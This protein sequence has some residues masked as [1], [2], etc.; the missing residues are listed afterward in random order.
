M[1]RLAFNENRANECQSILVCIDYSILVSNEWTKWTLEWIKF[2]LK[3]AKQELNEPNEKF[4]E[5]SDDSNE[6]NERNESSN[7][8]NESS[9]GHNEESNERDV[10]NKQHESSLTEM[11]FLCV[12]YENMLSLSHSL[13]QP[14][15][16]KWYKF[17]KLV[18]YV[19]EFTN[20]MPHKFVL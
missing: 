7:E 17:H 6:P 9:N 3:W 19:K 5:R 1:A 2:R 4:N 16:P 15:I 13:L 14:S 12:T 18:M 20:L 8:R 10:S 11:I